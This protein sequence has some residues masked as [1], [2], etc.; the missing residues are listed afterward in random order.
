MRRPVSL[1]VQIQRSPTTRTVR[2]AIGPAAFPLTGSAPC[3]QR[4]RPASAIRRNLN[5]PRRHRT[6]PV[7]LEYSIGWLTCT[8]VGS[9]TR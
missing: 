9:W 1:I 2:Q 6:Y 5:P 3:E 7:P 8:I 4:S